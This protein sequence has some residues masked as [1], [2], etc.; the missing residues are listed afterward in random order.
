MREFIVNN[1]ITLRQIDGKTVIFVNNK[2]FKQC[3]AL[4][5]NYPVRDKSAEDIQSIDEAVDNRDL[6]MEYKEDYVNVTKEEEFI[7]HCSNLQAW[8]ENNYNTLLL[9]KSIA[10]S[11]LHALVKAGDQIAK[12]VFKEEIAYRLSSGVDSV[13]NFLVN[14]HYVDYLERDQFFMS[15]L[16]PIES[17]SM[18]ELEKYLDQYLEKVSNREDFDFGVVGDSASCQFMTKNKSVVALSLSWEKDAP[19]SLP[20]SIS[21]FRNLRILR[22]SGENVHWLPKSIGKLKNLKEL[23]VDSDILEEIPTIITCLKNLESLKIRSSSLKC[24]LGE[25]RNLTKLKMLS[26]GRRLSYIPKSIGTLQRLEY[27]YLNDNQLDFIPESIFNLKNLKELHLEKNKLENLSPDIVRLKRLEVLNL[28]RN[29]IKKLPDLKDLKS[30]RI[31][32][33]DN[34]LKEKI[35]DLEDN[36]VDVF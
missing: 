9:H 26:V 11:L 22:Y 17:E 12:D 18:L 19:G 21:N 16:N 6:K 13:I 15:I 2:E 5:L 24:V 34:N 4:F 23:S 30:L 32:F 20:D 14:E 1:F 8:A 29:K 35:K 36:G 7:G 31:L 33:V 28:K 27:L 3:K 25:I 10:F